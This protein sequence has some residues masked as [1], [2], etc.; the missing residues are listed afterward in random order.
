M[1]GTEPI[2]IILSD[3]IYV[4]VPT[5]CI[6][7]FLEL[8]REFEHKNPQRFMKEKLGLP[9][10]DEPRTIV[11]WQRLEEPDGLF[12]VLAFPRGGMARVRAAFA[13]TGI[14]Y[15]MDDRRSDGADV[16]PFTHKRSLYVHQVAALD[17]IVEMENCLLRSPTGCISG[18]AVVEL[19]RAGKS[20]KCSL[21][22]LVHMHGG[23]ESGG[24]IWDAE[25]PTR[26]RMRTSEG[27]IRLGTVVDAYPSGTKRTFLVTTSTGKRV[28]ATLD[29]RFLG[30][31]GWITLGR[32]RVGDAVYVDGGTRGEGVALRQAKARYRV[33][34]GLHA[35]PHAGRRGVRH[36]K[37]GWS[38]PFHRLVAEASINKM[39]VDAFIRR[40]R[41]GDVEGLTFLDPKTHHVHHEDEDPKNNDP[42]NLIIMA[43][44][45]HHTAH[46]ESGGW[47]KVTARAV[48][49]EI[50]G[51][52]E[53]LDEATFDVEVLEEDHNFLAD[54][55]VVHNS[56][57]TTIAIAAIARTQVATLIIVPNRK[58]FDQWLVRVSEEL[59]IKKS[60]IGQIRGGKFTLRPVTIGIQKSV[61]NKAAEIAEEDYFGMVIADEVSLFAAKTFMAAIDPLPARYR[62]GV[63]ADHRR[64]D[65]KEFLIHDNFGEVVMHIKHEDLIKSGHVLDVEVRIVPTEFRADWYGVAATSDEAGDYDRTRLLTEMQ[66][67]GTRNRLALKCARELLAQ[68]HQVIALCEFREHCMTIDQALSGMGTRTGLLLGGNQDAIEFDR[69]AKGLANGTTQ[70]GVGTY[71]SLTYGLDIPRL[72]CAVCVTPMAGNEQ[73][74]KQVRGRICRTSTGKS[75]AIMI[76]LWDRF[77]FPDHVANMARWNANTVVLHHGAWVPAKV[78]MK[79]NKVA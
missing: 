62:I 22:H 51:I 18:G 35:H 25:I 38:I 63:S 70:C 77:V 57:K 42:E 29:H 27:F 32:L 40:I 76:Y 2:Q 48:L 49:D 44:S 33:V 39:H 47:K 4:R 41:S 3:R 74:F 69:V 17:A 23:G 1:V 13:R 5:S 19:N 45:A 79:T 16:P 11:T 72:G 65:R 55:F 59:G 66:N 9:V 37:G 52:G 12:E 60:D 34:N 20:F 26:I 73:V 58:L 15:E 46:G 61:A 21:A 7:L 28:R 64:K 75:G 78:W 30:A 31:D 43:P 36:D 53:P 50:V 67:D 54:G 56:G 14:R 6:E 71:K 10:W 68:G 24:K 8:T